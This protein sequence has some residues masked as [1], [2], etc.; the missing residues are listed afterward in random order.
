MTIVSPAS[1][2]G[3]DSSNNSLIKE[4]R[5]KEGRKKEKRWGWMER[6]GERGRGGGEGE[7]AEVI[8]RLQ[9]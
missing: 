3:P 4:K 9:L 8:L 1:R 2:T 7:G 5:K 6:G